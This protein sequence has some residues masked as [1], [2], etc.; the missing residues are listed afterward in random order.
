MPNLKQ[1]HDKYLKVYV[2]VDVWNHFYN[3]VGSILGTPSWSNT[4]LIQFCEKSTFI[5]LIM[6]TFCSNPGFQVLTTTKWYLGTTSLCYAMVPCY[7]HHVLLWGWSTN[8]DWCSLH[9]MLGVLLKDF[10]LDQS[11][12]QQLLQTGCGLCLSTIYTL[13]YKDLTD[14]VLLRCLSSKFCRGLFCGSVIV[15]VTKTVNRRSPI[16]AKYRDSP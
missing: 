15:T 9:I 7:H 5:K 4:V 16:P 1:K 8:R 2:T 3:P 12:F 13:H 11:I 6:S 14:E 10:V